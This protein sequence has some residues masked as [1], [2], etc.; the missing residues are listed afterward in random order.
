MLLYTGTYLDQHNAKKQHLNIITQKYA[1]VISFQVM[2][3]PTLSNNHASSFPIPRD[4]P[5]AFK[6]KLEVAL[7]NMT[8]TGCVHTFNNGDECQQETYNV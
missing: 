2:Q 6:G 8:H 7:M 5:Y 1:F 4:K 3:C